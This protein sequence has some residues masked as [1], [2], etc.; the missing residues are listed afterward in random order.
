MI[1]SKI[2][3]DLGT[4]SIVATVDRKGIIINEPNV[5][6]YDTFTEK[7]KAIGTEAYNML[8]RNPDS[9]TVIRPIVNGEVYNYEALQQMLCFFVQKICKNQIFKPSIIVCVPSSATEL[10]KKNMLELVISSGAARAC[11]IE[12]PLAAALGAGVGIKEPSGTMIVNIGAGKTDIAVV[13]NGCVCVS[14]TVDIAGNTFNDDICRFLKR[15]R[16]IIIGDVTAEAIKKQISCAKF[17]EA[18]L[19]VRIIGK[20]YLTK[21]PKSTEVSSSDVFLC[22]REHLERIIEIIRRVLE[23]TPPELNSDVGKNGIIITGGGAL[24]RGIDEYI[25]N[26]LNIKTV[27]AENPT[28]CVANGIATLLDDIKSLGENGYVFSSNFDIDEYEEN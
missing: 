24:I 15:E 16:D 17:L 27:C 9:L 18:E 3:F 20:S 26:K 23:N 28:L 7:V 10:D 2:G 4:S 6:A 25:E 21:M 5:I 11:V 12:E 1:G 8:G 22:I 19:A 13:S 14:E